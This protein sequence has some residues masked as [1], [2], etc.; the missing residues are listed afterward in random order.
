MPTL[1]PTNA[2]IADLLAQIAGLLEDQEDNPYRVQAF[3]HGAATVR[4]TKTPLVE[5][6][7]QGG[8][9]ALTQLEGIGEGLAGVIFEFISTGHSSYL[10]QVQARQSPEEIFQ[11]V[12]GIGP[13]LAQRIVY[14]L[15][16]HSLE[17]LE[18]AAHD[19][20]LERLQGFGPR[21]V[22][23]IQ[24][25]LTGLLGSRSHTRQGAT[26][27]KA[28]ADQPSVALLLEV[29]ADYRREAAAGTLSRLT[30]RR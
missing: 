18:Q 30:P 26:K 4:E 17:A 13:K 25:S 20:R 10:Q 21:R 12:P 6:V 2:K 11:R 16:L 9:E 28:Q 8:G 14:E 7:K 24:H 1:S 27:P 5:M 29:D 19:G 23:A 3:R 15:D 22:A